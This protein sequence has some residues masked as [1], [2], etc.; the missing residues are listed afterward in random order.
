M[1]GFHI[2]AILE[3]PSKDDLSDSKESASSGSTLVNLDAVNQLYQ[4]IL[5]H[6]FFFLEFDKFSQNRHKE[7]L[8]LSSSEHIKEREMRIDVRKTKD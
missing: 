4:K 1:Q 7:H 8:K 2:I 5:H 3:N 6:G